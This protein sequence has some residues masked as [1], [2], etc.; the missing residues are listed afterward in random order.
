MKDAA[1]TAVG[2]VSS[3]IGFLVMVAVG[4]AIVLGFAQA[5]GFFWRILLGV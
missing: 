2:Q 4:G 3:A 1:L 5:L